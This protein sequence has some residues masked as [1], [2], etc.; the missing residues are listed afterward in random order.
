MTYKLRYHAYKSNVNALPDEW[1]V[2]NGKNH[3]FTIYKVHY[4]E[5]DIYRVYQ[6]RTGEIAAEKKDLKEAKRWCERAFN[7]KMHMATD[8]SKNNNFGLF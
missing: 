3:I 1:Q 2:L 7:L 5:S 6:E 8:L 4:E